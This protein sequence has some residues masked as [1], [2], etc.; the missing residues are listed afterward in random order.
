MTL[1]PMRNP[2]LFVA[3]AWSR[4]GEVQRIKGILEDLGFECTNRWQDLSDDYDARE[5]ALLNLHDLHRSEILVL[6]TD[7]DSTTGGYHVEF[8]LCMARRMPIILVGPRQNIYH[9]LDLVDR[10]DTVEHIVQMLDMREYGGRKVG[11]GRRG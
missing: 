5:S 3:A 4:R 11:K 7:S 8:G 6:L 1:I 9:H 10:V 2:K